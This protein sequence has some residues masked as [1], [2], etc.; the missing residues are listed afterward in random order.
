[1]CFQRRRISRLFKVYFYVRII[2]THWWHRP[3]ITFMK[4]FDTITDGILN[5]AGICWSGPDRQSGGASRCQ[6]ADERLRE[7]NLQIFRGHV[8]LDSFLSAISHSKR[9]SSISSEVI[10]HCWTTTCGWYPTYST[11]TLYNY[12]DDDPEQQEQEWSQES[13]LL[14]FCRLLL[15]LHRRVVPIIPP[16]PPKEEEEEKNLSKMMLWTKIFLCQFTSIP[17]SQRQTTAKKA[18]FKKYY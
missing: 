6:H 4:C 15:D 16:P 2:F 17:L 14:L 8:H 9:K 7:P 10:M 12:P 11:T 13:L 5:F 1:M 18:C 3:A